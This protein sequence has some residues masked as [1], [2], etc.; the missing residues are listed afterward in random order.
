MPWNTTTTASQPA[1]VVDWNSITRN[2]G[3]IIDWAQVSGANYTRADGSKFVKAGVPLVQLASGKVAPYANRPGTE[4]AIGL[5]MSF[6]DQNSRVDPVSGYGV[7]IGGVIYEN[8]LPETLAA[9][10][11]TDLATA[12][13]GFSWQTYQDNREA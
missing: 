12:G 9:G 2:S 7:I 13:T 10:I 11:K 3:R 1:F 6:A 8:L 4:T 5:L